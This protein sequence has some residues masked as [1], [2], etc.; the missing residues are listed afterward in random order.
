MT[1][2]SLLILISLLSQTLLA[3]SPQ[4]ILNAD[5]HTGKVRGVHFINEEEIVSVSEDKSIRW[6]DVNTTSEIHKEYLNSDLGPDGMIFTSSFSRS[7]SLLA[8]GGFVD[9]G[10]GSISII[11]TG[12][13][14]VI[15]EIPAFEGST[16]L[17]KFS[18]SGSLLAA[19]GENGVVKIWEVDRL[20]EFSLRDSLSLP[21]KPNDFDIS[22]D[23]QELIFANDQNGLQVYELKNLSLTQTI[24]TKYLPTSSIRYTPDGKYI[25]AAGQDLL[26]SLYNRQ[27]KRIRKIAKLANEVSTMS[28]SDDAKVLTVIANNSGKARSFSLPSGEPMANFEEHG[29][30]AYAVDFH[31]NSN[32][33]SYTVAS[34]GGTRNSILIWN[35]ING[36]LLNQMD[37]NGKPVQKL[38]IRSND[39]LLIANAGSKNQFNYEFDLSSLLISK[40]TEI[41]EEGSK[42]YGKTQTPYLYKNAT[43]SI[44]NESHKDGRILVMSHIGNDTMLIGSDFSLKSYI[45]GQLFQ[46]FIGH[47][48]AVRSIVATDQ[49]IISGGEDE[50][51]HFW[52][53]ASRNKKLEPFA[54][55]YLENEN[56]WVL[57][58]ADGYF[59]SMGDGSGQFGWLL[60]N[61]G[62]FASLFTGDQFFSI[63]YQPDDV[64]KS[65]Q[66]QISVNA[67]LAK[68]GERAFALDKIQR[69]AAALFDQP[70]SHQNGKGFILTKK[71]NV[72]KSDNSKVTIQAS[73]FDGGSGIAEVSI[74]QNTKLISSDNDF[75]TS[76]EKYQKEYEVNLLPGLNRFKIVAKNLQGIE[77]RADAQ[78]I[79]YTGDI[80]AAADLHVLNVGIDKYLNP[81]Y[82]LNYAF[83]DASAFSTQ[84]A[85][86]AGNIFENVY[87]H[88]VYDR[89][90]TKVK[91]ISKFKEIASYAK[92]QDVFVFYYA[93]HG[94]IDLDNATQSYFLVPSDVTQLYGQ[95]QILEKKAISAAELKQLFAQIPAQK[96]LILLDACHSGG[97]TEYFAMRG[98]PQEKAIVQLARSSGTVMLAASGS[99]QYAI[100][101]DQ[102]GHGVFT[103]SLLEGLSGKADGG[104]KDGKITVNELKAYM[105]DIVPQISEKYGASAQFP[106]GFS[107]GQDFPIVIYK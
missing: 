59:K 35:V 70:Y 77:S 21:S 45:K 48:G 91:I 7:N 86:G 40:S 69:I 42:I 83:S 80:K 72:Y 10:R 5:G 26:L 29:N 18:K 43:Y 8:V 1:R 87:I 27:G 60:E 93:G 63:L 56:E 38:E 74:F 55:L 9:S 49:Y 61:K 24:K 46:E 107:S 6:W 58:T 73:V 17:L 25:I 103:Y 4:L 104:E 20:N 88:G 36:A 37:G 62:S 41:I 68:N 33:G 82:N 102:L 19:A 3:Q 76:Q 30:T 106:T 22:P 98:S 50:V 31:P 97:A 23:E 52:N 64:H 2:T 92:P 71:K 90:A 14:R 100:E 34:A 51:I 79:N 13:K 99:Q 75:S 105:E 85:N 66:S 16:V 32:Q 95:S 84:I 65:I 11:H 96:Q 15:A 78:T 39:R 81:N 44:E 57:W 67:L 54:S 89:D 12:I 94:T 28:I 53:R 101:F 47:K